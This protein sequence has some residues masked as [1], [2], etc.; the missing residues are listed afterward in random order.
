MELTKKDIDSIIGIISAHCPDA[1]NFKSAKDI[2]LLAEL[3]YNALCEYPKEVVFNATANTLKN[4]EYQKRN[5]LGAINLE[6]EKMKSSMEKSASDLWA[7]LTATFYEV[8]DCAKSLF[9]T[10]RDEDGL[11]QADKAEIRL[12]E[13]YSSLNPLIK[14][15]V[16]RVSELIRLARADSTE[17][18][19]E[20]GRFMKAIPLIRER[21]NTIRQMPQEVRLFFSDLNKQIGGGKEL[22]RLSDK[23]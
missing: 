15:Y 6:I 13:I 7:E 5:W 16:R 21:E 8:D 19:V 3:W 11:T 17:L 10:F 9:C 1:F 22:P 20:K 18:S 23:K 14:S 4:S 2:E 12:R